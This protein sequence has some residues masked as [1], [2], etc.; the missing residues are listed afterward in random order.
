MKFPKKTDVALV[1][2]LSGFVLSASAV[3]VVPVVVPVAESVAVVDHDVDSTGNGLLSTLPFVN[4]PR[5]G[6]SLH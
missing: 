2:G 5:E 4:H 3:V 1:A 6:A